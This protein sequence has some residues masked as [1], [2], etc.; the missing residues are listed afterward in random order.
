VT[1]VANDAPILQIEPLRSSNVQDLAELL[2]S[3]DTKYF[4]H[5]P[6]EAARRFLAE[7]ADVHV[8]GRADGEV[9][10]FGMLRGWQEGY[11]V[12]SLGIAVRSDREGAGY[13]R[14]MLIALEQLARERGASRIRLRVHPENLRARRLYD[15][16]GYREVGIERGETLMLLDL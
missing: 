4:A 16:R 6:P 14:A 10:A 8:L 12:P 7:P 3:V 5:A 13:G 15:A 1:D 2:G 11:E 9:V